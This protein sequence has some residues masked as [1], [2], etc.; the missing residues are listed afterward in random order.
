MDVVQMVSLQP[1]VLSTRGVWNTKHVRIPAMVAAEMVIQ[2]LKEPT[3]KAVQLMFVKLHYLAVVMMAKLLLP[4]LEKKVNVKKTKN[5]KLGSLAAVRMA[6][7][8]LKD[9]RNRDVLNALMKFSCAMNVRRLNLVVVQIFKMQLLDP[10]LRVVR[11]KMGKY[12]KIAHL[13]NMV[14]VRMKMGKYMK[15]A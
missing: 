8:S 11:M 7:L 12:M 5:A 3:L 9:L 13:L 2:Q 14:V 15:I 4:G 10:N 1:R 6:A